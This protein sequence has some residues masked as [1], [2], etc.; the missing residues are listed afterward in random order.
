MRIFSYNILD[1]GEGRA[2]PLA[3]V[4][5][6]QRADCVALIE[7]DNSDVLARISKRLHM[8]L[9]V[10]QGKRHA[11]AL[12]SRFPIVSSTNH[13][14]SQ[15][16]PD[17]FLEALVRS[18]SGEELSLGILHL[19]PQA[20]EKDEA[21]RE[22]ELDVVLEI[23]EPHRRQRKPHFLIGDFNAN[24]PFQNIDPEK[25]KPSTREGWRMNGGHLPR[26]AIQKVLSAGYLDSLQTLRPDY[27]KSTGTFSTQFPG[28]R[29][30]Y[31]FTSN[32]PGSRLKNAWI[33]HDRLAKYASD[34]FPVGLEIA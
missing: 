32:I 17:C 20:L 3:E 2:D 10:G 34:H 23:F 8:D 14:V 33:E 19:H 25:C 24:S 16:K 30:D 31:I 18:P 15:D 21:I 29:V 26:T 11:V 22:E 1:G 4:I 12:L 13:A 27:A 9:L 28:Q 6:A 5:E 7:A